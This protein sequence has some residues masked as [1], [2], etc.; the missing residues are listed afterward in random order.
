MIP[1]SERK[2]DPVN[3]DDVKQQ[4][5]EM[6]REEFDAIQGLVADEINRRGPD[7]SRLVGRQ[8]QNW[9]DNLINQGDQA[10]RKQ[11]EEARKANLAA[12]QRNKFGG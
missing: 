1:M 5:K 11:A 8:Y 6:P 3:P 4:L 12:Q 9:S 7:P 10:K 2:Y